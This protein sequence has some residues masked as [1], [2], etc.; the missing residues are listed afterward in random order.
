MLKRLEILRFTNQQTEDME[1]ANW[2]WNSH[3][4]DEYS[5]GYYQCRWCLNLHT[6]TTGVSAQYPLC[7]E[8]PA[9]KK[10]WKAR[11]KP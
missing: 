1:L 10:L 5:P 9:I 7:N 11:E 2:A 3:Y 8:N 4:W 6:S